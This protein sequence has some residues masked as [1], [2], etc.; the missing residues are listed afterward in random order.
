MRRFRAVNVAGCSD[1]DVSL[2]SRDKHGAII[3]SELLAAFIWSFA[4]DETHLGLDRP[5]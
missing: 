1:F 2:A 5:D 4:V 3:D